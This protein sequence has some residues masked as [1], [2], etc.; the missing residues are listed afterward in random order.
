M[1][2]PMKVAVIGGTG[3]LGAKV[4]DR[5]RARG[6]EAV[7]VAPGPDAYPLTGAGLRAALDGARVVVDVIGHPGADAK[8]V[9]ALCTAATRNVLAVAEAAGVSHHVALSMVGVGRIPGDGWFRAKV[10]QEGLIR[11][12]PVPHSIV[13]ATQFFESTPDV[14]DTATEGRTVRVAPVPCQP[15]AVDDVAA[16][17]CRTVEGEPLDEPVEVAGP[18]R[19]RLDQLVA[20]A[21]S[22]RDDPRLV[23]TDPYARY[24][25]APARG[26]GLIPDAGRARI[27]PTRFESWL[28]LPH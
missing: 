13:R 10:A 1:T 20:R 9:L 11:R 16:E 8:E 4:V 5:L 6:H 2:R 26:R 24:F 19:F 7:A 28:R 27:T 25:G 17:L 22:A 3:L 14:A 15:V 21:L 23:V 18:E 12:S